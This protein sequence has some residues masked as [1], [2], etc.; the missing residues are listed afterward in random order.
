MGTN[1]TWPDE[2]DIATKKIENTIKHINNSKFNPNITKRRQKE[3][4]EECE[5][6]YSKRL[7]E[8]QDYINC[9][10]FYLT[11]AYAYI[12]AAKIYYESSDQYVAVWSKVIKD[13]NNLGIK[14]E[15]YRAIKDI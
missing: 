1:T 9:I 7:K 14:I 10:D 5:I 3:I 2:L 4:L 8:A 6:E 12:N 11:F 13:L 15:N